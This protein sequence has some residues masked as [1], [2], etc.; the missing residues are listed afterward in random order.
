MLFNIVKLLSFDVHFCHCHVG[1]IVEGTIRYR[2][3][4]CQGNRGLVWDP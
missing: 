1:L 4:R 2:I 3:T